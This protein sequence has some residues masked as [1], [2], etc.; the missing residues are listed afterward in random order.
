MEQQFDRQKVKAYIEGLKFLKA[1]NQELLKDIET[2]AK[3]APVEGCE[4]FMKAMY[5]ALK[6]NEDNIKGAIEY[7]EEEIK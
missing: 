1:K 6:Q 2:V 5:D 4:R 3:D 7:W